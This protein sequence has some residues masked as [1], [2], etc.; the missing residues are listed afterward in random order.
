MLILI[1]IIVLTAIAAHA[2][3]TKVDYPRREIDRPWV[4]PGYMNQLKLGGDGLFKNGGGTQSLLLPVIEY[5]S[6]HSDDFAWI[7]NPLPIGFKY[8]LLINNTHR[9]GLKAYYEVF[10]YGALLNYRLRLF[11]Q[12][13]E[14]EG[15][16][17]RMNLLWVHG[18][19]TE[20]SA[21]AIF[22]ISDEVAFM[23]LGKYGYYAQ[24]VDFM[25]GN[26]FTGGVD[27]QWNTNAR[28]D[29]RVGAAAI[30]YFTDGDSQYA[31]QADLTVA[32]R[33]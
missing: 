14:F 7:L 5:E 26:G 25:D 3:G 18:R 11:E 1:P 17:D 23:P 31:T 15:K 20:V 19:T 32:F 30:Y 28:I 8:Q 29:V 2:E 27:V 22:Q 24:R 21:R 10:S 16:F 9:L 12:A 13:I 6:G 33:F 4:I